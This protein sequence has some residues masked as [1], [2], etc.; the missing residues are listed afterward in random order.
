MDIKKV[1]KSLGIE[2]LSY[3]ASIGDQWIKTRGEKIASYSPVDGELIL[4]STLRNKIGIES[5]KYVEKYHDI[6]KV[7]QD[8][9]NIYKEI[10]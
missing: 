10:S 7:T 4:D 6:K 2:S 3:G 5:R 9:I 8:T 1:L